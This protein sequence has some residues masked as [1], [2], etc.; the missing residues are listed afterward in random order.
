MRK[1][2]LSLAAVATLALPGL[3]LAQE[4]AAAAPAGAA[5]TDTVFILN[6]LLFLVGGFLVFWM[7]AGF[8]MSHP[9]QLKAAPSGWF[10]RGIP[11]RSTSPTAP[12]IW[13]F[14]TKSWPRAV[15]PRTRRAGDPSSRANA[16]S[17]LR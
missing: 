1:S 17:P 11:S 5:A 16:K 6:S 15:P 12:S 13:Q 14:R 7:A 4:T 2:T 3:A 9:R 8:A 10:S